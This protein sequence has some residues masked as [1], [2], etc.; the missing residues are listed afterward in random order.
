MRRKYNAC[1]APSEGLRRCAPGII[2]S[3]NHAATPLAAPPAAPPLAAA[4]A[5]PARADPRR[6]RCGPQA[7]GAGPFAGSSDALA[8]AQLARRAARRQADAR[9]RQRRPA[10]R[11]APRRGNPVVR[12]RTCAW[13]CC[14]TGRRCPTTISRRTRT[15]CP[16]GSRR[17]IA[18]RAANATCSS[19]PRRP[20]CTGSRRRRTSPRSRSSCAGR[21]ARR[22]ARCAR[23][24]RSPATRT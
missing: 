19:S 5:L 11:A 18:C 3:L 12:A 24:W 4:P 7:C 2:A 17:S 23:S 9:G 15:S 8:L 13:R 14:P 20:R 10:V 16:S 1:A 6:A 22:R 21:D